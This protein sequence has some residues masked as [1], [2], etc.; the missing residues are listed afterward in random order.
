MDRN[1]KK[2]PLILSEKRDSL[3]AKRSFKLSLFIFFIDSIRS[4]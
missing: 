1:N 3:N 4:L 2:R